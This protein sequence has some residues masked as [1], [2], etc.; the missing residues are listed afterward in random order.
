MVGWKAAER[1]TEPSTPVERAKLLGKLLILSML[2]F[3]LAGCGKGWELD[4]GEPVAQFNEQAVLKK[5]KPFLGKKI[6]VKGVVTKQDL[7]DPE[8]CKLY[9]HHSICCNLGHFQR[10]AE[11]YKVGE[12]VFID[13]FL[14]RCEEGD[15][16][17]EPAV[18]RDPKADFNPL[19]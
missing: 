8:N 4:Y 5:A 3:Q 15:I 12:T 10:M 11:G 7:T 1:R 17:L 2:L 18:G 14:N 6:T 16:L 9:W 13:G 19:E